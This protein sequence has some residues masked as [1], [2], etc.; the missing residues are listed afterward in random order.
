M[1]GNRTEPRHLAL[2]LG[3]QPLLPMPFSD[4]EER[5]WWVRTHHD[6]TGHSVR[7]MIVEDE[8]LGR[9]ATTLHALIGEEPS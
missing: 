3:C 1:T 9:Y 5:D 6:A 7:T 8:S 2:C 4:V